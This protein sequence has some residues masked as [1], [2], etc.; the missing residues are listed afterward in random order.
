MNKKQKLAI[1]IGAPVLAGGIPMSILLSKMF[2]P[3]NIT[4]IQNSVADIIQST[5]G[6][7]NENLFDKIR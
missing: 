1:D 5:N 7:Y 2:S 6:A 3:E 4:A